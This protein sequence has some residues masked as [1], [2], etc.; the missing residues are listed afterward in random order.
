MNI[1]RASAEQL[2][3]MVALEQ[4]C[5]SRPWSRQSF[6]YELE[7]GDAYV[8]AAMEGET[9]VGFAIL[10]RMAD[11]G[12]LFNIAVDPA[13]RGRGAGRALLDAVLAQ[14]PAMGVRRLYLEVRRSNE[15]ART[16]YRGAG[17]QVCGTRKNYYE[18]PTEDAVLME[19]ELC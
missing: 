5:F 11:E 8:A 14:A 2:D 1:V 12:E 3:A 16:L 6:A 7:S 17:F 18:G 4:L 13:F 9:L 10:H 19:V 15:A